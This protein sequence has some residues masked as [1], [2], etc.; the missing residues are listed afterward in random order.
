MTGEKRACSELQPFNSA[1]DATAKCD[2]LVLGLHGYGPLSD[3]ISLFGDTLVLSA[4]CKLDR[5]C[6]CTDIVGRGVDG[7]FIILA[8]SVGG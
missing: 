2:C 6:T 5:L 8:Q 3:L 1:R 7:C 4:Q